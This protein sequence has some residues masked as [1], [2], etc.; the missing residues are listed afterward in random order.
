MKEVNFRNCNKARVQI[1]YI[2]NCA[3]FIKALAKL[4]YLCDK[5]MNKKNTET[6]L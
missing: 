3:Y 5:I 6:C 1:S 2:S 4:T